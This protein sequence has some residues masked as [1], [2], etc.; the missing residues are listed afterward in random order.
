MALDDVR[1]H[2]NSS[3][4][5]AVSAAAYTRGTDIHVAPGQERHLPHEAWHVVQQ[6]Q[7]RVP[8]TA[9]AAGLPV[10]DDAKLEAEADVM[11]ARA[12]SLKSPA[13]PPPAAPDAGARSAR[14]GVVQRRIVIN[15][16]AF[17]RGL[18][19][20]GG[21]L[22]DEALLGQ[23][24]KEQVNEYIRIAV[25][26][27]V[28]LAVYVS[29]Q[30]EDGRHKQFAS[31]MKKLSQAEDPPAKL[32]VLNELI[33]LVNDYLGGQQDYTELSYEGKNDNRK[34]TLPSRAARYATNPKGGYSHTS[35]TTGKPEGT[36]WGDDETMW[37]KFAG[38]AREGVMG[39]TPYETAQPRGKDLLPL[40]KLPWAEARR[41]LPRPLMNLI[42]DVRYQLETGGGTVID[43]R[44]PYELARREKSPD[45]PGTLRSWHQDTVGVLP[46]TGF[47]KGTPVPP[48]AAA[49]HRH[50][51]ESSTSG[52][53][54]STKNAVRGPQG[55]AEYTGT[56]SNWEHNTKV[57]LDY[58]NKRV[59]LTLTHYQYWA[60][61]DRGDG[62]YEFW[63]TAT[64]EL[65]QAQSRVTDG[66]DEKRAS[67]NNKWGGTLVGAREVKL[68]SPWM[69]VLM[70]TAA[71]LVPKKKEETAVG[72][73]T[74]E[75][76]VTGEVGN[77]QETPLVVLPE[78]PVGETSAVG[79]GSQVPR[80]RRIGDCL[81]DAVNDAVDSLQSN[82]DIYRELAAHWFLSN[83]AE[84]PDLVQVADFDEIVNVLKQPGAWSGGAGDLSPLILA[85]TLGVEL[86]IVTP[87]V[88]HVYP[89]LGGVASRQ[90]TIFYHEN[91]Y[92]DSP[93]EEHGDYLQ[94][95]TVSHTIK[96]K[97]SSHRPLKR[98]GLKEIMTKLGVKADE[99]K[100]D[101]TYEDGEGNQYKYRG[102]IESVL[103]LKK[104]AFEVTKSE[105]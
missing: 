105:K 26:D 99:L 14:E 36:K 76:G 87:E 4:P 59:Y 89:P 35:L 53:G 82:V 51:T 1:V 43:E 22:P 83:L 88:V 33:P 47:E 11:G 24:T 66:L 8:A 31:E 32:A 65:D 28:M 74:T 45:A 61:V 10:N 102:E 73:Q 90:V 69:E 19:S 46:G 78:Q 55:L 96:K 79:G 97:N 41:I 68:M 21:E 48:N 38:E 9:R 6:K 64:Q 77:R 91:H 23:V 72:V 5:A 80:A 16:M 67:K 18:H 60:L 57:V 103:T 70:P 17:L 104:H 2:Y 13:P 85:S 71:A 15:P 40:T 29:K 42:F 94:L 3:D 27:E 50:Y 100:V 12:L 54:S 20:D 25:Y 30:K 56:G 75:G 86:I 63:E 62:K 34:I 39:E 98:L 49:L 95:K 101:Q 84:Y 81:Y 93:V 92:T 44:T 7:G 37:R 52:V 58:I